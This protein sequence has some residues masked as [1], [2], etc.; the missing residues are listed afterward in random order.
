MPAALCSPTAAG[1][2]ARPV[3]RCEQCVP[4]VPDQALDVAGVQQPGPPRM[5]TCSPGRPTSK[6][7]RVGYG[8]CALQTVG[9]SPQGRRTGT[10]TSGSG[11]LGVLLGRS[12]ARR[13]HDLVNDELLDPPRGV[14]G[15]R[16]QG[17]SRDLVDEWAPEPA[18]SL[19]PRRAGGG[20]ARRS[21]AERPP[22]RAARR[23][24]S[25]GRARRRGADPLGG[26]PPR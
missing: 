17:A 14:R 2:P 8:T 7:R 21:P 18:R 10:R 6:G 19:D 13:A 16:P 24:D 5:V 22:L 23:R 9:Y 12:G 4:G 3:S 1:R 11:V 15:A 25:L 26:W 20:C